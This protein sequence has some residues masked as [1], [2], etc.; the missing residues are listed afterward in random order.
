MLVIFDTCTKPD[1]YADVHKV[2]A[3]PKD[4]VI[5]YD[6]ERRLHTEEAAKVLSEVS[7]GL[8][9]NVPVLLMYGQ[10]K[11]FKKGDPDPEFMLSWKNSIFFPVR[12]AIVESAAIDL[13]PIKHRENIHCHLRLKEFLDPDA[14]EIEKLVRA[15][16][17]K[18]ELPFGDDSEYK[19]VSVSPEGIDTDALC[20]GKGENW[21]KV[22]DRIAHPPSQFQGDVFWRVEAVE[23][24]NFDSLDCEVLSS[25]RRTNKRGDRSRWHYDYLIHD[26]SEYVITVRNRVPNVENADFAENPRLVVESKDDPS[27]L[28]IFSESVV[29]IRRNDAVKVKV[30]TKVLDFFGAKYARIQ[31]R[32]ETDSKTCGVYTPGSLTEISVRL[33]KNAIRQY[34]AL[35]FAFAGLTSAAAGGALMRTQTGLAVVLFLIG[36]GAVWFAAWLWTGKVTLPVK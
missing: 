15:L 9:H 23:I 14:P 2:L 35:V 29:P 21:A 10:L 28:L 20:Q 18:S 22:V 26:P 16:E 11:S 30:G 8:Q 3:A 36:I 33:E 12:L 27:D 31:L 25:A 5:K 7:E 6:Y 34:F 13:D 24:E 19:W 32:T 1:Y 17:A 4:T